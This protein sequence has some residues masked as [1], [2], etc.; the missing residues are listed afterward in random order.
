MRDEAGNLYGTTYAG[1]G[2]SFPGGTVFKLDRAGKETV[3]YNF[4]SPADGQN[5]NAG[6][7]RD[8]EGNLYG[9]TAGGG[10]YDRGTV[11]KLDRAGI[12]TV[13]YSFS[14]GTDGG[15][16]EAGLI[17]DEEGNLYGT[18]L[19]GGD[20]SGCSGAGCGVVFKVDCAGSETVLYRFTGGADGARPFAALIRDE[21]ANLYGTT[22]N[23]GE[24][25]SSPV[26]APFGCGVVFKLDRA[27]KET[28]L[29]AFT[30]GKDGA[31]PYAPL[32]RRGGNLYG[33]TL[34]GG[35]QDAFCSGYCGVVFKLDRT[36]KE[37]VL[38]TF[39]GTTDGANPYAGLIGDEEGNL[40]GTTGYGGDLAN[41]QAPCDGAGCGV[42]FKLKLPEECDDD[43]AAENS[44]PLS[45]ESAAPTAQN[46][47]A[48]IAPNGTPPER[49]SR[50]P[51]EPLYPM[52]DSGAGLNNRM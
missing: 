20:L 34:Y 27:G 33:T 37:T 14:A 35:N 17:R 42:V 4:A 52:P 41:T 12:E 36:G 23:G 39:T 1:G 31:N 6:V 22:S 44:T 3:L 45:R 50:L 51:Q 5:P 28:V 19:A 9:T 47:T 48:A 29:Y 30:G 43:S 49:R 24:G 38:Y 16:P 13:V 15:V 8:E 2:P 40:Y 32:L 25:F 11:F 46:P 26:C 10:A 18:T 7:I 21:E